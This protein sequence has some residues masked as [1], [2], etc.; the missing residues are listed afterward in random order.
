MSETTHH[1]AL[2]PGYKLFWYQIESV[3]GQGAFGITYLARDINL[4]RQVAIKEYMPGQFSMRSSENSVEPISNDLQTDFT[5][6]LKRFISEARTLTK[7]KHPNLVQVFNIFEKNNTAYMVMNYEVGKSLK[8]LLRA[9]KTLTELELMRILIPLLDGLEVMH[10]K[11]FIHRDIKPGNIFIRRNDS[12]VLLDFGSARQTRY[13][14][15]DDEDSQ[16][17]TLTN[18]VSPGYTPIEQ[19]T[20]KSDRQGPWTDIYSMG[21][22]LYKCITG[23]MPTEAVE[24]SESIVHVSKDEYSK[25]TDVVDGKYSKSFLTAIDHSLEFKAPHRPQTI[26][27]WKKEFG[28]TEDDIDTIQMPDLDRIRCAEEENDH[29]EFN[30]DINLSE[31]ATE[32]SDETATLTEETTIFLD[33]RTLTSPA[34]LPGKK[35]RFIQYATAAT[36]VLGSFTVF[37]WPDQKE[38]LTEQQNIPITSLPEETENIEIDLTPSP[39]IVT[40]TLVTEVEI[41]ENSLPNEEHENLIVTEETTDNEV[42]DNQESEIES[43]IQELL[44]LAAKDVKAQRL[45]V[46]KGNNAYE[47]YNEALELDSNNESAKQGILLLTDKYMLFTYKAIENNQFNKG[48]YYLAKADGISPGLKQID[49]AREHLQRKERQYLVAKAAPVKPKPTVTTTQQTTKQ[50]GVKVVD[51]SS[52]AKNEPA[53]KNP[54]DNTINTIKDW[55]D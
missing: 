9:K 4:D 44:A 23:K 48:R 20:G 43:Q 1:N 33:D 13:Y 55:F 17:K 24:R 53:P 14:F 29:A 49:R 26:E 41:E 40:E 34:L 8:Q 46:P 11:G 3:L 54:I 10:E 51:L 15:S 5:S 47:K 28:I 31:P 36:L 37:N 42:E 16:V 38:P 7:F 21:A 25:L 6:G 52:Q 19:Y 30:V 2:K 27:E 22:T 35:S 39:T 32:L 12:P 45:T 18:F 50:D